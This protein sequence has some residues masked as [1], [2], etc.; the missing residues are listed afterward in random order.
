MCCL[1]HSHLGRRLAKVQLG[2]EKLGGARFVP[3][4]LHFLLLLHLVDIAVRLDK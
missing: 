4:S 3:F 1:Q 2:V